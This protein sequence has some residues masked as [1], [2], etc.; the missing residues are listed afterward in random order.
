MGYGTFA[1][2]WASGDAFIHCQRE[3]ERNRPQAIKRIQELVVEAGRINHP[4]FKRWVQKIKQAHDV[5]QH[6]AYSGDWW[7]PKYYSQAESDM[8]YVCFQPLHVIY[9]RERWTDERAL[10]AVEW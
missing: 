7:G 10:I 6:Y 8:L 9:L 3:R 4:I 5:G 2:G 1:R